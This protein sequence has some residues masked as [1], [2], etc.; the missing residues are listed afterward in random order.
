MSQPSKRR[1]TGAFTSQTNTVERLA[2]VSVTAQNE[3]EIV[4]DQLVQKTGQLATS[5]KS[6]TKAVQPKKTATAQAGI[7]AV[8]Q[9]AK[10]TTTTGK[11]GVKA[12][13]TKPVGATAVKAGTKQAAAS[14]ANQNGNGVSKDFSKPQI[15]NTDKSSMNINNLK[16]NGAGPSSDSLSGPESIG[17]DKDERE[18]FWGLVHMFIKCHEGENKDYKEGVK[19]LGATGA[20]SSDLHSK[21]SKANSKQNAAGGSK[22]VK[23]SKHPSQLSNDDTKGGRNGVKVSASVSNAPSKSTKGGKR[24]TGVAVSEA[25]EEAKAKA[26]AEALVNG[27]DAQKL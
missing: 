17:D 22:K 6:S 12:P 9:G 21:A 18:A 13:A 3:V 14:K 7:K 15:N 4:K 11:G 8:Q 27:A 25:P 1:K 2:E 20:A 26:E 19:H 5:Q 24:K 16:K 23:G 10:E